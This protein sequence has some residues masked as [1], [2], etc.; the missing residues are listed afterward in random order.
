M[1]IDK[2]KYVAHGRGHCTHH[3]MSTDHPGP[4][5]KVILCSVSRSIF[6]PSSTAFTSDSDNALLLEEP[7]LNWMT[8]H[9]YSNIAMTWFVYNNIICLD[10]GTHK[11]KTKYIA[12]PHQRSSTYAKY[13][14]VPGN[15]RKCVWTPLNSGNPAYYNVQFGPNVF[16]WTSVPEELKHHSIFCIMDTKFVLFECIIIRVMK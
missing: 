3:L 8:V 16:I 9:T 13:Y 15:K 6:K 2:V 14:R 7:V 5:K 12:I 11:L 10:F 1:S 4:S